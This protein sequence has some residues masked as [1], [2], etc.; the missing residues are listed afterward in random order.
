MP[1]WP[2]EQ[3]EFETPAYAVLIA[4]SSLMLKTKVPL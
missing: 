2:S 1:N 3:F 4:C